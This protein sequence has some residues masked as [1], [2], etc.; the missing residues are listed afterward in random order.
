MVLIPLGIKA[1]VLVTATQ[2]YNHLIILTPADYNWSGTLCTN[3]NIDCN[4]G[5]S[6]VQIGFNL[7]DCLCYGSYGLD[8]FNFI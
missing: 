5:V 1:L 6:L 8:N 7:C 2:V 3:C 4:T